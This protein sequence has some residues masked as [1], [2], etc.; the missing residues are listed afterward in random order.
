MANGDRA[1]TLY[2]TLKKDR[3]ELVNT[4]EHL[5]TEI[6]RQNSMIELDAHQIKQ[7]TDEVNKVMQRVVVAE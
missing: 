1:T 6:L 5:L 3:D 4:T 7:C 2:D